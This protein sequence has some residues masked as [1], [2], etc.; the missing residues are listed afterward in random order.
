VWT[1][2]FGTH[3]KIRYKQ[4]MHCSGEI[5]DRNLFAASIYRSRMEKCAHSEFPLWLTEANK[6]C[7]CRH[8]IP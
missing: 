3:R 2:L 5:I 6:P 1:M 4:Y 8:S 7:I